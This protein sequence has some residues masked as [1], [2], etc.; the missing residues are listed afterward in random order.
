MIEAFVLTSVI[1]EAKGYASLSLILGIINSN[2]QM[3]RNKH[4]EVPILAYLEL[5]LKCVC[6][7]LHCML[8]FP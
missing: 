3:H 2:Y 1:A 7:I 8:S 4:P 6:T 5:T